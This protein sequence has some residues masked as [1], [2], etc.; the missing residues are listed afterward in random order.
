MVVPLFADIVEGVGVVYVTGVF[1]CCGGLL[2]TFNGLERIW[3]F[4]V[5]LCGILQVLSFS[6]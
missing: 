1:F 4:H 5:T 2:S 3:K 6:K